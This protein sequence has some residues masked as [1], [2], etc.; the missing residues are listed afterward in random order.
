MMSTHGATLL[1]F[2]L[3]KWLALSTAQ[4]KTLLVRSRCGL[5]MLLFAPLLISCR[6]ATQTV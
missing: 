6:K 5:A 4:T 3:R 2:E 1:Q